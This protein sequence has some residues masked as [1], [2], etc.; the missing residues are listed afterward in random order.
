MGGTL[1]GTDSWFNNTA[2]QVSSQYG[3]GLGGEAHQYV[4]LEDT[5]WANGVLEPGNKWPGPAGKNPN[6]LSVSIETEDNGS[7]TTPVTDAMYAAVFH[8]CLDALDAYPALAYLMDHQVISP[9]SR[10]VCAGNRWR[11]GRMQQLAAEL[12]LELILM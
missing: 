12:G 2:S 4:R 6:S 5:A 11:A 10:P 7:G 9:Q 3:V 8:L 1:A